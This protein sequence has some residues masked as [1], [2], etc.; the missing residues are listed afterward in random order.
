MKPHKFT[1]GQYAY[2]WQTINY[3]EVFVLY[4]L[5]GIQVANDNKKD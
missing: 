2:C 1:N 3:Y 5:A 4:L